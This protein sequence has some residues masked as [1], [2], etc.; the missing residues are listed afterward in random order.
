MD[1]KTGKR[2]ELTLLLLTLA[3]AV[4]AVLVAERFHLRIDLSADRANTLSRASRALGDEIPERVRIT[5]YITPSLADRHPGPRAIEDFLRELEAAS[6]GKISV[7]VADPAQADQARAAEALG[8]TPQRMQIVEKNEQRVALVYSGI[9]VQYLERSQVLPFLIGTETLEYDMVK[10]VRAAVADKKSVA[11]LLVGDADKSLANDY[12]NVQAAFEAAGWETREIARGEEVPSD[13]SALIVLGNADLDDYDAYRVDA[14]VAGGGKALFAV[15]GVD[16]QA[17]YGLSAG[18]LRQR[19][20]LDLL[21]SY[22]LRVKRE[23]ALDASSLT[24]PFQTAGP[25]GGV[26][27]RYVRYPH[28]IVT[29]PEYRDP[30]AR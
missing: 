5:Y 21:E 19:A 16:V 29:R 11:A 9:V 4:A 18:P 6:K 28:W 3:T 1:I 17:Q 10:A 30:R 25:S 14:F 8:L 26:A 20:I 23:L 15:K 27:I 13:A 24:L 2:R 22:G 12:R 7:T